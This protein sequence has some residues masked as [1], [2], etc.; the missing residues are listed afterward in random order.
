MSSEKQLIKYDIL[1]FYIVLRSLSM[2]PPSSLEREVTRDRHDKGL[3]WLRCAVLE[4]G[5]QDS[6]ESRPEAWRE[7][8]NEEEICRDAR[9]QTKNTQMKLV[10]Y[11]WIM[12]TYITPAKIQQ[13]NN[14]MPDKRF[15][16]NACCFTVCASEGRE[17]KCGKRRNT[18][19][20]KSQC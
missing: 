7:N 10:Q 3:I 19:T 6:S 4:S 13:F 18:R 17:G 12:R 11:K 16:C 15:K 9:Q 14:N 5:A 20:L 1:M 8:L 2:R